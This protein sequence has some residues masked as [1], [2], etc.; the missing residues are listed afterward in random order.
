MVSVTDPYG[1]ILAFLD[2]AAKVLLMK[3][4]IMERQV[5]TTLH[6]R[7]SIDDSQQRDTSLYSASRGL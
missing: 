3:K 2:R 1:R 6:A 4:H 5:N 7:N